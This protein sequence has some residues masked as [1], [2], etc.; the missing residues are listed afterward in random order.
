MVFAKS[1][2][3]QHAEPQHMPLFIDSLHERV[4]CRGPHETWCFTK[5][6]FKIIRLGIKPDLY[7]FGHNDSPGFS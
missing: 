4:M 1:T 6:N 5:L 3:T 2:D 7:F